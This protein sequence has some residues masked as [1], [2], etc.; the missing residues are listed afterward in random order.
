MRGL[1]GKPGV[2][3]I[4]LEKEIPKDLDRFYDDVHLTPEG[5]RHAGEAITVYLMTHPEKFPFR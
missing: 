4:D 3:L 2:G 5:V 1:S